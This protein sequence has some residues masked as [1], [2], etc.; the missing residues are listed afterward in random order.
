MKVAYD[1]LEALGLIKDTL[2]F[3]MSEHG[4]ENE[5]A[6]YG[7]KDLDADGCMNVYVKKIEW[8]ATPPRSVRLSGEEERDRVTSMLRSVEELQKLRG[9]DSEDPTDVHGS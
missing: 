7:E 8:D 9:S 5:Y 1:R 3:T 6:F 2:L 4:T